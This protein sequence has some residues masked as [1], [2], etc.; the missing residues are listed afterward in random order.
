[1]RFLNVSLLVRSVSV[2]AALF[3]P[4]VASPATITAGINEWG[5]H[6]LTLD[7]PIEAGDPRRLAAAI[8]EA[9]ARGYRLDALRL[10]SPGGPIWE[11]MAMAVMVRWVENMATAVQ[12][13]AE[14]E[15]RAS[16][17]LP[18]AIASMSIQPPIQHRSACTQFT[19]S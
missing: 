13:D 7:G 18:R 16:A 3:A 8:L 14:C 5:N 9:N 10:N 11:A 12:K 6:Y 2:L 17:Y 15:F 19:Q 4:S 1:M